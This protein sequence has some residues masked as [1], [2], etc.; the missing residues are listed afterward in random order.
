LYKLDFTD[1]SIK[2]KSLILWE[3]ERLRVQQLYWSRV[4]DSWEKKKKQERRSKKKSE[5]KEPTKTTSSSSYSLGLVLLTL[6]PLI[7]LPN[8]QKGMCH[9]PHDNHAHLIFLLLLLSLLALPF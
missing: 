8:Y 3:R 6:A 5:K 4:N 7:K 9:H 2:S 1:K